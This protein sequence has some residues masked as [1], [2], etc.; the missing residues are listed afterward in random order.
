[1]H[2]THM[3][4]ALGRSQRLDRATT[5]RYHQVNGLARVHLRQLPRQVPH[6]QRINRQQPPP[7]PR[8]PRQLPNHAHNP[9]QRI[10]RLCQR[11]SISEHCQHPHHLHSL[12]LN[13]R[14]TSVPQQ[15]ICITAHQ[16]RFSRYSPADRVQHQFPASQA[17]QPIMR[18]AHTSC[19]TSCHALFITHA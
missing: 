5:R 19:H 18:N 2:I 6:R 7:N 16:T 3:W 17:T 14:T 10:N 1:M 11:L 13:A 4:H 8:S 15:P 12:K 9:W